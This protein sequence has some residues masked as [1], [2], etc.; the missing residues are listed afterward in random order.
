MN[1]AL[2]TTCWWQRG[3]FN[4]VGVSFA[5]AVA[6]L[7]LGEDFTSYDQS[8]NPVNVASRV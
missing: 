6:F 8:T 7:L 2:R 1:N 3:A 4:P 5:I